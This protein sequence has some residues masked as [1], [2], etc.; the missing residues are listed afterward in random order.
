MS[1]KKS[2]DLVQHG[3][4]GATADQILDSIRTEFGLPRRPSR[5]ATAA[6]STKADAR[7]DQP[8]ATNTNKQVM[9]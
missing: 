8:D 6:D 9:P 5:P 7:S 4:A 1:N 3:I 2:C